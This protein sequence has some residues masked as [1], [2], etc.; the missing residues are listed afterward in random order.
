[1]QLKQIVRLLGL[2]LQAVIVNTN[3]LFL[4]ENGYLLF[5]SEQPILLSFTHLHKKCQT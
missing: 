2:N 3:A 4:I 5:I 1:M